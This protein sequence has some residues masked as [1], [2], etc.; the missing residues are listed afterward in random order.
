MDGPVVVRSMSSVTVDTPL[1]G[2]FCMVSLAV[3]TVMDLK[4]QK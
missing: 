4:K 1:I 2:V 3:A